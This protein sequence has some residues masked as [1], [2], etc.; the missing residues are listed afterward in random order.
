MNTNE[1]TQ[2]FVPNFNASNNAFKAGN[3]VPPIPLSKPNR[4]KDSNVA[5]KIVAGV[6]GGAAVA[7][8]GGGAIYAITHSAD[9][10]NPSPAP[11]PTP[12]PDD[13]KGFHHHHHHETHVSHVEH[14]QTIIEQ[15]I[16]V[17]QEVEETP[18]VVKDMAIA[19]I[20]ENDMPEFV[21]ALD[22]GGM[23][24]FL[25]DDDL[26]GIFNYMLADFNEDGTINLDERADIE[27][28]NITVDDALTELASVDPERAY[29]FV[30]QLEDFYGFDEDNSAYSDV[31]DSFDVDEDGTVTL[32]D[33]EF[34]MTD[35]I[36]MT[37][38]DELDEDPVQDIEPANHEDFAMNEDIDVVEP[39]EMGDDDVEELANIDDYKADDNDSVFDV[40]DNGAGAPA[41]DGILVGSNDE[42]ADDPIYE[43]AQESVATIEVDN[44]ENDI[45]PEP[46]PL[47]QT[48]TYEPE[49]VIETATPEPESEPMA[50]VVTPEPEPASEPEPIDMPEENLW[51]DATCEMDGGVDTSSDIAS[52]SLDA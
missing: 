41:S 4:K 47:A 43:P 25:V 18:V 3:N 52:D 20:D 27:H 29:A 30:G 10:V 45:A 24:S 11:D 48:E 46:E 42:P 39:F 19:D 17:S 2:A 26:D 7:G 49:P 22:M 31:V 34:G 1:N 13:N 44:V 28:L 40:S 37:D 36:P 12:T 16:E 50:E 33:D 9:D 23:L 6:L 21:A 5:A 38:L 15:P 51:A 35:E 14:H 8:L 32:N